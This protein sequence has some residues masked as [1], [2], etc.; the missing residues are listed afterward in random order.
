MNKFEALIVTGKLEVLLS[1]G[2]EKL[3]EE[4]KVIQKCIIDDELANLVIS[5]GKIS[6]RTHNDK[7]VCNCIEQLIKYGSGSKGEEMAKKEEKKK[8]SIEELGLSIRTFN[9]LK[10]AGINTVGDILN[11]SKEEM[12]KVTRV[13]S[14]GQKSY[15]DV[16]CKMEEFGFNDWARKM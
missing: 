4:V 1:S 6:A 7:N 5:L 12:A 13:K 2:E 9:Y 10:S 3:L 15:D 8:M 11:C 14:V 16:L